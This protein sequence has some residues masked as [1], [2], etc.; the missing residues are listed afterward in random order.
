VSD[1]QRRPTV[2]VFASFVA[3]LASACA[4]PPARASG[5]A[6]TMVPDAAVARAQ[7]RIDI[8][9]TD[10][11]LRQRLTP[12]QYF[13][14]QQEGTEPAYRNEYWDN[15]AP[16]LY[17]DIITGEPLFS[18]S[19]KY[20]SHTGWPSFT[21]PLESAQLVERADHKLGYLRRELRTVNSNSH[22]GHVF[23]DGPPPKGLRY[24]MNS[25]ALRFIPESDLDAQGYGALR[26]RV[27]T[28]HSAWDKK[29]V[30]R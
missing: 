9:P 1:T 28:E 3:S 17:V 20:D 21:Q 25:A 27:G 11:E 23:E 29:T 30:P 12:M 10:V 24:C 15:H 26:S 14:T 7:P 16:G 5:A 18:S 19:D 2:F 8:K 22:L 6:G 4:T 13:V